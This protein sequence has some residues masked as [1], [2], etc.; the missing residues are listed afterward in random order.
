MENPLFKSSKDRQ[1]PLVFGGAVG[2][3]IWASSQTGFNQE[4]SYLRIPQVSC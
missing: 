2:R 3:Q 4:R 1:I